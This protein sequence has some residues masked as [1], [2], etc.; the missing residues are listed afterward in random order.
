MNEQSGDALP[1]KFLDLL[2]TKCA[3]L[4]SGCAVGEYWRVTYA[5]VVL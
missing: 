5:W 4:A 1:V 3:L 2:A